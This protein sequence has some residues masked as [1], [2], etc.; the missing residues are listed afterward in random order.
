MTDEISWKIRDHYSN[1]NN[2]S[3]DRNGKRNVYKTIDVS[4]EVNTCYSTLAQSSTIIADI[5][6]REGV[7]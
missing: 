3:Y 1:S 6:R 5:L 4:G 2:W 7:I